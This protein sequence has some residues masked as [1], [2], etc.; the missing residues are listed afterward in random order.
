MKKSQY[1]KYY[2]EADK[3][4]VLNDN[5]P[6]LRPIVLSLPKPPPLHLI[7]GYGLPPEEQRFQRLEIPRKLIDLEAEAVLKTKEDLSTNKN[8][9]VTLLKIQKKFWELLRERHKS[10]KK[11]IAFIRRTWWHRIFGYWFFNNGKPTY[12]SGWHFYYLNFWTMDVQNKISNPD[13]RDRDRKEFLFNLYAYTTTETFAKLDKHGMAIP[14]EDGSYDMIDLGRRVCYGTIQP[15][16]RRSGNTNK[17]LSNGIEVLTRTIGTDGMGCQSYSEDNARSHFKDKLMPA[18][19]RL[20]VWLKPNTVSGRTSDSLKLDVGKNDYGDEGLGTYAD[21]ATT[22]SSRFYDGKKKIYLLT[23]EAGKTEST[24]VSDRHQ[25]N[26]HTLAQGNGADI[27]GYMMYPS[28][29]EELKEGAA[30][31]RKLFNGSNF[32][33]RNHLSGQTE[34]GLFGLFV[35]GDEGLDKYIDPYGYSVK[36]KMNDYYRKLGYDHTATEYLQAERTKLLAK[37]DPESM[38]DYRHIRK[39]F[40]LKLEDCWL[41]EAGD[42]GFD[43]EKIDKRLSELMRRSNVRVGNLEW[44][45]GIFGGDVYFKDDVEN[46]RFVISKDAVDAYSNKKVRVSFYNAFKQKTEEAWRPMYPGYFTVGVDTFRLGG[47]SDSRTRMAL[48]KTSKLSDGGIAVLWNY[49]PS[50]DGDKNKTD[51]QSYRF[52]LTYRHR[53]SNTDDFNE[54]VLKASIWYGGMVFPETNVPNTYEYFVKHG[55]GGY[56]LYDTDKYSGRLKDKPGVD[57]LERSKQE[58]FSLWRDYIDYRCHVEE[59]EDLLRELKTIKELEQMRHFDII[60]AGG[61]ALMG[62][63]SSYVETLRRVEDH[64][65]DYNDFIWT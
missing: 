13:Y 9:V 15:K 59:H 40:P 3:Y 61:V 19:D 53:H 48:S 56:L 42:I 23:D 60:A 7:D 64:D 33:E 46:G 28:T 35:P 25:V 37:G 41:G 21:Y 34:S 31:Y 6:D 1:E 43:L 57:T 49:D 38:H 18:Y 10:M 22:S 16:N 30:H 51:W 54:D 5:D 27:F 29:V 62:A 17:A 44:V 14:N 36:G 39:L 52:V 45:D 12:I 8:N 55:F 24:S 4:V 20:P 47:K 58:I 63:K 50:L 26:K 11:E 2:E 65:Y 32:Y